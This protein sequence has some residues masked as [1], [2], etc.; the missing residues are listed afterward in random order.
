MNRGNTYVEVKMNQIWLPMLGID[1]LYQVKQAPFVYRQGR[2][3]FT[4]KRRVQFPHGAYLD[5]TIL[6]IHPF[7][8]LTYASLTYALHK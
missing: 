6:Q 4:A 1:C 8:S 2:C 5:F 3:P 7:H